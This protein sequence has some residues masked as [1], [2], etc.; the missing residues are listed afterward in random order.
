MAVTANTEKMGWPRT[1]LAIGFFG[2]S[3]TIEMGGQSGIEIADAR[4]LRVKES[5]RIDAIA[6]AEERT[7][8]ARAAALQE[9]YG[10][11]QEGSG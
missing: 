3:G 5:D 6:A 10:V 8:A 1:C 11:A 2:T 7:N 9:Q 4:E